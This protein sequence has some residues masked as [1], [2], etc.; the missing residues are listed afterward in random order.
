VQA[1]GLIFVA[2]ACQIFRYLARAAPA[3]GGRSMKSM[4]IGF[5]LIGIVLAL[6]GCACRSGYVGPYGGVHPGGCVL[7]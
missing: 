1:A 4:K 6:S 3:I 5:V 2:I 7:F